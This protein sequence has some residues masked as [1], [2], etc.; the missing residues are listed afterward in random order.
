MVDLRPGQGRVGIL[1][2]DAGQG[3]D[4]VTGEVEVAI[5]VYGTSPASPGASA[6][7]AAIENSQGMARTKQTKP[8]TLPSLAA[9]CR[10]D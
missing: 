9:I 1:A 7:A 6:G 8:D 4:M 10:P 2:A 3:P 5:A